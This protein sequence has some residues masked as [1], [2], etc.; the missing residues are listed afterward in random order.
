LLQGRPLFRG[1]ADEGL[2]WTVNED[3]LALMMD[4]FGPLPKDLLQ[5]GKVSSRYFD[6]NGIIFDLLLYQNPAAKE[7]YREPILYK[8]N[9]Q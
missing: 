7:Y 1:R 2:G 9:Q 8:A 3:R 4:L 5:E 6:D